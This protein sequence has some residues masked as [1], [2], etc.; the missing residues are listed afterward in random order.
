MWCG[1]VH[2]TARAGGMCALEG[3]RPAQE[4]SQASDRVRDE[5]TA[6]F[7]H[8]HGELPTGGTGHV[9]LRVRV[10]P[11]GRV[12]D[13][14][15]DAGTA[16][17]ALA[18]CL[19]G[20]VRALTF[21]PRPDTASTLFTW[22]IPADP[23]D[24]PNLLPTAA[25]L[26]TPGSVRAAA[27]VHLLGGLLRE[28]VEAILATSLPGLQA[29]YDEGRVRRPQIHGEAMF[30]LVI[31]KDGSVRTASAKASTLADPL[32]EQCAAD[33]LSRLQFGTAP[34]GGITIVS[35]PLLFLAS[36]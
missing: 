16:N 28:R 27:P 10:E 31:N 26:P 4:L 18:G 22:S 7:Q 25:T 20:Q 1:I 9:E 3:H 30:E 17:P 24:D 14:T 13:A 29:C 5:L 33:H 34:G 35:Y 19:S 8:A 15:W 11:D 32:V 12:S 36:E 21:T 23:G 6:C 2:W